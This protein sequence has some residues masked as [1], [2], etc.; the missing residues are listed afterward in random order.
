[1][2]SA[3]RRAF[4]PLQ[5][6]VLRKELAIASI[7]LERGADLNYRGAWD[8]PALVIAATRA[9][10]AEMTELLLRFGAKPDAM[11]ARGHTSLYEVATSYAFDVLETLIRAGANVNFRAQDGS[12]P[13]HQ[14]AARNT[15]ADARAIRILVQHG[16]KLDAQDNQGFTPLHAAL[17]R[18]MSTAALALL[19]LGADPTIR[20]HAGRMPVE[21]IGE[22]V[23]Q[24][25]GIPEV[26]R[27]IE[28]RIS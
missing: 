10:S 16:A 26:I 13:L 14:A 19:D 8:S 18:T 22:G 21:L 9:Y 20:D 23:R 6:A 27:R 28:A 2:I 24:Y 15:H 1:M 5:A 12:T 7:L 3:D 11:D 17:E 4:S 25:P